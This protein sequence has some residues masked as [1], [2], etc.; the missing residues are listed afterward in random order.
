MTS[1]GTLPPERTLPAGVLFGL[2]LVLASTA[3]L[4]LGLLDVPLE[5][6]E[7]E[8]A[9]VAQRMLAGEAP[10]GG[11]YTL[12]WPGTHAA[13]AVCMSVFGESLRGIRLGFLV[14]HAATILL[15]FAL[16]RRHAEAWAAVGGAALYAALS[17]NSAL[18]GQAA[19]AT[20]FVVF[21]ALVAL[22][23]TPR[24]PLAAPAWRHI[25]AGL[26]LGAAVLA[27]QTGLFL[28]LFGVLVP[29]L[30]RAGDPTSGE[31]WRATGLR[32]AGA[33]VIVAATF[34]LLAAAG[35]FDRF[36]FWTVTY[37][38]EYATT[39]PAEAALA[40]LERATEVVLK[41]TWALWALA[42]IGLVAT[43]FDRAAAR[44]RLWVLGLTLACV[45]ALLPGL[46]FRRHYFVLLLPAAAVLSSVGLAT[47]A[48][49]VPGRTGGLVAGALLVAGVAVTVAGDRT[50]RDDLSPTAI[51]RA[52]YGT[53][54]FPEAELIAAELRERSAPGDEVVVFG[55]E[56]ELPFLAGLRSATGFLYVYGLMEAHPFASEMQRDMIAE[57]EA[58]SPAFAVFVE[59]PSSWL[60]REESDTHLRDWMK[61][62]I[63]AN[64]TYIG[65][66]EVLS[67]TETR[68]YWD[69]RTPEFKPRSPNF[70]LV[71]QRR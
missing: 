22:V 34:G 7:G 25:A 66:V 35:V 36:W 20:H 37:A 28:A 68:S 51:S 50:F 49:L 61:P 52:L 40:N 43:T 69:E 15:V 57:V 63:D 38:R 29:W 11:A 16:A 42:A 1:E 18:L 56:P 60:Q 71:F 54:P 53:N 59:T 70:V 47:L 44:S 46:H 39:M 64:Y 48:R 17:T 21:A 23:L 12:K 55:S 32:A 45:L 31:R 3:W 30:V 65:A 58:A 26:L 6:D 24:D 13:Y 27:K 9:Y 4:R 8:Y 62:W 67:P 14:L 19:H 10:Y 2:V 5:R 41:P 33:A